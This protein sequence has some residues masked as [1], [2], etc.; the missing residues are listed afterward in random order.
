MSNLGLY[1]RRALEL[2]PHVVVRKAVGLA[3]RTVRAKTQQLKDRATSSYGPPIAGQPALAIE[4]DA[5]GIDGPAREALAAL[6]G[7]VLAHRF[8]LLGS[9]LV[10]VSYGAPAAGIEG[11]TYEV[12]DDVRRAGAQRAP[13][14]LLTAASR[15]RSR[16]VLGL[17][18]DAAWRPIDWQ[19]DVRSGFRWSA[20]TPWQQLRIGRDR[21]ADI[22]WPWELSR[23]QHLPQLALAA[24]LAKS[25]DT[26]F[27]AADSYVREIRNEILDFIAANPPRY[28]ACWGCPMDVGIRAA[29][30][31]LASAIVRGAGIEWDGPFAAEL[32]GAL[33][34]AGS[35]ITANLEWAE[36][37]R[38]NHYLSDVVGLLF[39]AA[40]L[41]RTPRSATWINFAA[42]EILGETI[43]QFHADGGNFEG[44]TSY[45]R[46]S[47]DLAAYGMALTAG[48]AQREPELFRSADEPTVATMRVPMPPLEV[49]VEDLLSKAG[50]R[51]QPMLAVSRAIR[52]PD[53]DIIQIG[54][55]DSGRLFKLA[56]ALDPSSSAGNPLELHLRID[57]LVDALSALTGSA[58]AR[59][60][61]GQIAAQLAQRRTVG[62]GGAVAPDRGSWLTGGPADL[63][64]L[65]AQIERLPPASRAVRHIPLS[66]AIDTPPTVSA[67]ADFGLYVLTA[68]GLYLAFRAAR[69]HRRDAPYGHTHD[70]NL[71]LEVVVDGR[72]VITDPGTY[73]YTSF[74]EL[75]NAWR[76][77][78]AHFVP[79]SPEL[80]VV[81]TTPYLF[82]MRH[83][84]TARCIAAGPGGFAGALEG[85]AGRIL[86]TV[87]L[88]A[89]ALVVRD[90][91]EGGTLAAI[92]PTVPVANGYGKKTTRPVIAV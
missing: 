90:G 11:V 71:G 89:A 75:R 29:N 8:D 31:V 6:T 3:L 52:R 28:G 13:W 57:D 14:Q 55:T 26:R 92:A 85:P 22:K 15:P 19:R 58:D 60:A 7:A 9:G 24:V 45:H 53:G 46:L 48:L 17:I 64:G 81:E 41:P 47:A 72:S 21:G 66:R 65:T 32:L 91:V 16:R 82:Q 56:P 30:W 62:R 79:R 87:T 50:E 80:P 33:D 78:G 34:D 38:S 39:A 49:P 23:M 76:G 18:D 54:D 5:D 69:H 74:P 10:D 40:A 51:L 4:I 43:S 70:D 63:S 67:F 2:P 35:F 12:G 84:M 73:V 59:S 1:V 27:A 86:R 36:T 37:G 68:P 77:A 88:E 44:S 61:P 25:G 20:R 42:R 83:L